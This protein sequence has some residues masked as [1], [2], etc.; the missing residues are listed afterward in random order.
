MGTE[1]AKE[2]PQPF[3]SLIAYDLVPLLC[4]TYTVPLPREATFFHPTLHV[5][6]MTRVGSMVG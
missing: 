2:N 4:A 5:L 6:Y 1:P 3:A